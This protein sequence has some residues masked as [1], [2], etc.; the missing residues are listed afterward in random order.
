MKLLFP[1]RH[2]LDTKKQEEYLT[3]IIYKPLENSDFWSDSSNVSGN[4]IDELLFVITSSDQDHSRYN[5]VGFARRF[6]SLD[7]F[8]KSISDS[9]NIKYRII[10]MPHYKNIDNFEE[11]LLKEVK[12]QTTL[13]LSP[14]NT[15][16]LSSTPNLIT[17][18]Q[19]SGFSILPAELISIEPEKYNSLRPLD[20]VNLIAEIGDQWKSN[21]T[22]IN[23]LSEQSYEFFK[24]HPD[25]PQ[26]ITKLFNEPLLNDEGSLTNDRDYL[27]YGWGMS[28]QDV[29][30]MK[31][32]QVRNLILPGKIVDEGCADGMLLS[33]ISKDFH[34]SDLIGVEITGEFNAQLEE[35]KRRGHFGNTYIHFIQ[36]NI[37]NPVFEDNSIDTVLCNS[38]GHELWSYVSQEKT[39]KDYLLNKH[40]QLRKGGRIVMRDVVG[41]ENKQQEIYMHLNNSNGSDENVNKQFNDSKE[42]QNHL[43]GL[44]TEARFIRFTKDYHPNNSSIDYK[45][46]VIGDEKFYIL[47][48]K[49]AVEF[50]TK[51]DYTDNWNS[52]LNE[53]FAFWDINEW[54]SALSESGFNVI[55]NPNAP[56]NGSRTI[57]NE[58]VVDNKWRNKVTLYTKQNDKL[59]QMEYPVTNMVLVGEKK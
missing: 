22:L 2:V 11:Y 23:N 27:T 47:K 24:D 58:Y 38:T 21:Q 28:N 59:I 10:G 26:R 6:A 20:L 43:D 35:N 49:D 39:I 44:S 36:E 13:D 46:E 25:I 17:Q 55:E 16:I 34:D 45:T 4:S 14:E 50:M 3:D 18:F 54:K 5:P 1:G 37:L 56:E 48:L 41:P 40:K 51:K 8:A 31:Y 7:R 30:Q 52:E 9:M 29:I 15:I 53:E 42:L 12:N 33:Y 32:D 19:N 57:R